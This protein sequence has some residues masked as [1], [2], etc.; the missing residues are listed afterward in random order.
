MKLS[1]ANV[2]VL[3]LGALASASASLAE[4]KFT[5]VPLLSVWSNAQCPAFASPLATM[6]FAAII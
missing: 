4:G 2:F 6:S 1:F 3:V 5:H